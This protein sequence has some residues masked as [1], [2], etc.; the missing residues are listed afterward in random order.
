MHTNEKQQPTLALLGS[1]AA[2]SGTAG[3]ALAVAAGEDDCMVDILGVSAPFIDRGSG[4][5][6]TTP[7][8][9]AASASFKTCTIGEAAEVSEEVGSGFASSADRDAA[10]KVVDAPGGTTLAL[11]RTAGVIGTATGA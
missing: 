8:A 11:R 10:W 5:E 7:D 4:S 1:C 3:G 2:A 9:E 6:D